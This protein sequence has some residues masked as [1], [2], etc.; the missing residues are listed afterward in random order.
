MFIPALVSAIDCDKRTS[1][2]QVLTGSPQDRFTPG[3]WDPQ[4]CRSRVFYAI[5]KTIKKSPGSEQVKER[6]LI[7]LMTI[8]PNQLDDTTIN[9]YCAELPLSG[10]PTPEFDDDFDLGDL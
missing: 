2:F 5:C 7:D 8:I 1:T 3:K 9:R 6:R 4:N 10:E